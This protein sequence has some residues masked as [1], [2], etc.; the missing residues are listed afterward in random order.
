MGELIGVLK[1]ESDE[2]KQLVIKFENPSHGK[3]RRETQANIEQRF[4]GGTCIEKVSFP[5]SLSKSKKNIVSTARVIQ[6]PIKIAFATTSHKVQGQTVK[7]PRY[8]IV[9]LRSVFQPAMAY[10]MLSR[11]ESI[12]Q[13]YIL[14]E[15]DSSKI[16]GSMQ[17]IKELER[18]NKVAVN[19]QPSDWNDMAKKRIRISILNCGSLRP[20]LEH[21]RMDPVMT[22]SD[23]IC[24]TET[25][26]WTDEEKDPF[27]LEGYDVN[28]NAVGRGK[29]ISVYYKS[30]LITHI[31]DIKEDKIQVS[32]FSGEKLDLLVVYRAPNGNDGGLRDHITRLVDLNRPTMVCGDFNMCYKG[33]KKNRTTT[34]LLKNGFNQHVDEATHVEG[35]HI[36]HVYLNSDKSVDTSVEIHSPYYTALDHDAVCVSIKEADFQ[37]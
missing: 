9:D 35:G 16:Y 30:S 31:E 10:V 23:I 22:V 12:N 19:Q 28:H 24:L 15:C 29:G 8:V 37:K 2:I 1:N 34:F 33:N 25:W 14:E 18:M 7:K 13:L 3:M 11:V 5:F 21:I 32:K 20:Q 27:N 6:F 17:A 36:D 4:P 26:L